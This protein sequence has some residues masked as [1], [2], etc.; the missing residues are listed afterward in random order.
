MTR[1]GIDG[2]RTMERMA[3]AASDERGRDR[4][5]AYPLAGWDPYE[6]W[7]SRVKEHFT[8]TGELRRSRRASEA[9]AARRGAWRRNLNGT[10]MRLLG[11]C[12]LTPIPSMTRGDTAER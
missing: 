2:S 9:G 11:A 10:A 7:R 1:N 12:R 5:L 8:A 3:V 4:E 6:V